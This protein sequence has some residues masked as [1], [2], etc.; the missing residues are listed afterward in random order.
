M[1]EDPIMLFSYLNT[2]LRDTYSSLE[3]LAEDMGINQEELK[4]IIE[5]LLDA[6]FTYDE[7]RNQFI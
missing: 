5:K 2:K 4:K 3:I 1:P 6:G 7:S